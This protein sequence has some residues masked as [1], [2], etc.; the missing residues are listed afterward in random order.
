MLQDLPPNIH[1]SDPRFLEWFES[2]IRYHAN[3]PLDPAAEKPPVLG[4]VGIADMHDIYYGDERYMDSGYLNIGDYNETESS[5]IQPSTLHQT[6]RL[7]DL[8]DEWVRRQPLYQ[9]QPVDVVDGDHPPSFD[10]PSDPPAPQEQTALWNK[11][12]L[13]MA[14][15][16][17]PGNNS[18]KLKLLAQAQLGLKLAIPPKLPP[19][20]QHAPSLSSTGLF[21]EAQGIY[22][23]VEITNATQARFTL[24]EIPADLLDKILVANPGKE[25]L[26]A[27]AYALAFATESETVETVSITS[28]STE[29]ADGAVP[30]HSGWHLD[31]SGAHATTTVH[32]VTGH[33]C[34]PLSEWHTWQMSLK[35]TVLVMSINR[36]GGAFSVSIAEDSHT[37]WMFHNGK[38]LIWQPQEINGV[39]K[40]CPVMVSCTGPALQTSALAN[41]APIYS[42][43]GNEDESFETGGYENTDLAVVLYTRD[44]DADAP[45]SITSTCTGVKASIWCGRWYLLDQIDQQGALNSWAVHINNQLVGSTSSREGNY[46]R[47]RVIDHNAAEVAIVDQEHGPQS[48]AVFTEHACVDGSCQ[49]IDQEEVSVPCDGSMWGTN[50]L[51][52]IRQT[53]RVIGGYWSQ[54]ANGAAIVFP[55]DCAEGVVVAVGGDMTGE[56]IIN[57]TWETDDSGLA[58]YVEY[59]AWAYNCGGGPISIATDWTGR[60]APVSGQAVNKTSDYTGT[61]WTADAEIHFVGRDYADKKSEAFDFFSSDHG[62]TASEIP[63]IGFLSINGDEPCVTGFAEITQGI[64]DEMLLR[65]G[66]EPKA[67]NEYPSQL[68]ALDVRSGASGLA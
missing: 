14:P 19:I 40:Y 61:A 48:S 60:T 32:R 44:Y 4:G 42:Y 10:Y 8:Y 46:Y 22:W 23:M 18:G 12:R 35:S 15:G 54:S 29:I 68:A 47:K 21:T 43:Y 3:N 33:S 50:H 26:I 9:P 63:V 65:G 55:W 25:T 5:S 37:E 56:D 49:V 17:K 59:G 7:L 2:L 20:N 58:A 52:E 16:S 45:R 67:E 36:S 13:R 38:E 64:G 62:P 6:P 34:P 1:P 24:Y 57:R 31:W 41:R 53:Y 51:H 30:W 27:E 66:S 11:T 28:S 39:H